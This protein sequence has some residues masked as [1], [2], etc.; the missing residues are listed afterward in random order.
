MRETPSFNFG[1][2]IAYL[3]PGFT[4][5][6]GLSY[7]SETVSTWLGSVPPNA[8]TVGGFLYLTLA[9]VAAGLTASTIRWAVIDTLHH[10]TGIRQPDW[11]FRCLQENA[12]AFDTL[13]ENH[14]R[15]Y[16]FYGNMA[17]ALAFSYAALW[18]A[19]GTLA[20]P[21]GSGSPGVL[22]IEVLFLAGSRDTLAKYYSRVSRFL[23]AEPAAEGAR[24]AMTST[25]S[26]TGELNRSSPS[27]RTLGVPHGKAD[28]TPPTRPRRVVAPPSRLSRQTRRV[29]RN[30]SPLAPV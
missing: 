8:P 13:G 27:A 18:F 2:L 24:A 22:F 11:D 10:W 29:C 26:E 5:L 25:A 12:A 21:F 15:Y 30:D 28:R 19:S 23:R 9:S 4:V 6:W 3:I 7:H 17:V 1:F 14:Y 20:P 16:Q